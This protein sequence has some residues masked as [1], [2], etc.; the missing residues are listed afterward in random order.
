M[1]FKR[2][3]LRIYKWLGLFRIALFFTK[4]RLRIVCYHGFALHDEA[5][6]R[7]RL[8]IRTETFN[9]RMDY[10]KRNGFRVVSLA[11]GLKG[12]QDGTLPKSAVVLTI[13]DGWAGV[14]ERALPVL[15]RFTFPATIYITSYFASKGSPV[16]RL[17]IQYLFW[18]TRNMQLSTTGL[19]LQLGEVVPIAA[20]DDRE[21]VVST[22][23]EFGETELDEEGRCDLSRALADRLGVDYEE[24]VRTRILGLMNASEIRA[25]VEAGMDVQLHTHRHRLPNDRDLVRREIVDNRAFLEPLV[26][27][28]L[29]HFCYPSGIWSKQQWPWLRELGIESATTCVSGLNQTDTPLLSL[30]RFLDGENVSDIEFEAELCGVSEM[31]RGCRVLLKRIFQRR[32]ALIESAP[33]R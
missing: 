7:P 11:T 24:L 23:M 8:F 1:I 15:R 27:K 13:D 21:H 10:L 9:R 4:H 12:L 16:F 5:D 6:F 31:L 20:T 3:I 22:I 33:E 29:R 25:V 17:I 30:R 26:G 19:G 2:A 32:D 28:E 14:F 18:K